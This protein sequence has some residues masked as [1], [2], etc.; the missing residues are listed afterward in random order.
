MRIA[1]RVLMLCLALL[2]MALAGANALA[3]ET[4]Q[5]MDEWTVMFYLCGSDL[6]SKY[7][8]ASDYLDDIGMTNYPNSW[9]LAVAKEYGLDPETMQITRPGKVNVLLQ[10]GGSKS[11]RDRDEDMQAGGVAIDPD[12]LQRWRYDICSDEVFIDAGYSLLETLPLKSMAD[13]DTLADFIRW[14][15]QTC[16]AKKYALVLWG[17]GGGALTGLLVDELFDND[18][19]YLYEL[20]QALAD[21]GARFD[22]LIID[23]CLMANIETAWNVRESARWLVASEEEVPGRGTAVSDWLQA[24]YAYP[25]CDGEWL[26]RCVC[27]MTGIMYAN[28]EDKIAKSLLTWSVVDLEKIDRLVEAAGA[29]FRIMGDALAR[30]PSEV[31]EYTDYIFEAESYGDGRQCMYDIGSVIYNPNTMQ[32]VSLRVRGELMDA[33][34]D[35]VTYVVRGPGRN[36]ARGLSFCYPADCDA[37][38]LDIYARNCPMPVYLAYIDAIS[39]W[40]APDWVYQTVD[41]LPGIDGID[42]FNF[43]TTKVLCNDGFPGVTFGDGEMSMR[44]VYYS[45]YRLDEQK[46]QTVLLGRTICGF[47][48][49]GNTIFWR[50]SDPMHWPAIDGEL[51]CIDMIQDNSFVRLYN[52]PVQIGSRIGMLRCGRTIYYTYSREDGTETRRSEYEVYGM[53]ED[54]DDDSTLMNRSVQPLATLTG[55]EFRLLY[56]LDGSGRKN[57]YAFSDDMTMYRWLEVE[58]IPLPAGT[59]YI[60]YEVQDIFKRFSKIERFEF[61]WDGENV[62]FPHIDEWVDVP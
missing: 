3:E 46:G 37:E 30:Y 54:Y 60:Q 41:P 2:L 29:Y 20:R 12:A 1:K 48:F 15:K 55:Q 7:G 40:D 23:A 36:A 34:S 45:L 19:M 9:L 35:A 28:G 4:A 18:V 61:R 5:E 53:W 56:P 47:E 49:K 32:T 58:E 25:E 44:D 17:H 62:T 11:W 26:G 24:L 51:C 14:G 8:Y 59:Y 38:V 31:R 6:E 10:T 21:G 42:A 39:P 52:I 16:P 50:A 57:R 33:L 27:D 13:A 43:V 22:A